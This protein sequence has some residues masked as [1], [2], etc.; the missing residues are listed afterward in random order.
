M[1]FPMPQIP[2][3]TFCIPLYRLLLPKNTSSPLWPEYRSSV[4]R[5]DI[6]LGLRAQRAQDA[7]LQVQA[8]PFY[9][10]KTGLQK[11]QNKI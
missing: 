8:H 2:A 4:D 5:W 1:F 10:E 6:W 11:K 9:I 7:A 3:L